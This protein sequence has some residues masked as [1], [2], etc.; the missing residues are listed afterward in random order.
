LLD[1]ESDD[2]DQMLLFASWAP[3]PHAPQ[4]DYDVPGAPK[5]VVPSSIIIIIIIVIMIIT[6]IAPRLGSSMIIHS[7]II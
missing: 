3:P 5:I 6:Y 7:S 1:N 4:L 2:D